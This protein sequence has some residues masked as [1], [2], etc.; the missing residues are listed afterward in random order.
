MKELFHDCIAIDY[1]EN[2]LN[3][4]EEVI[5][6]SSRWDELFGQTPTRTKRPFRTL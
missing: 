1:H 5:R 2:I 6:S 3:T 4:V